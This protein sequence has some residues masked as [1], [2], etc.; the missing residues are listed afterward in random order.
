MGEA[1]LAPPQRCRGFKWPGSQNVQVSYKTDIFASCQLHL[2]TMSIL[3][4]VAQPKTIAVILLCMT[5]FAVIHRKF[6]PPQN[7]PPGPPKDNWLFGHSIPKALYV[8]VHFA[9]MIYPRAT[10]VH[11]ASSKNGHKSTALSSP[12]GKAP[13]TL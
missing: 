7:L 5:L 2:T 4:V 13:K 12:Y 9:T 3:E 10:A 6:S 11:I 1:C 8:L